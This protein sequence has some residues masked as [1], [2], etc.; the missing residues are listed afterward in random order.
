MKLMTIMST[1]LYAWTHSSTWQCW[2]S[3]WWQ[4]WATSCLSHYIARRRSNLLWKE[5]LIGYGYQQY[6]VANSSIG[7][8]FCKNP[9]KI[10][11]DFNKKSGQYPS[12]SPG[13]TKNLWFCCL[14][15]INGTFRAWFCRLANS[16]ITL[17]MC[18]KSQKAWQNYKNP[19][20]I[21]AIF[22][23]CQDIRAS[24]CTSIR[25]YDGDFTWQHS[26]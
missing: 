25:Q 7:L 23:K 11:A 3:S 21:Q 5:T 22:S 19:D 1:L 2:S 10:Q 6:S 15:V 9:G 16:S 17:W 24:H 26:Q 18:T 4:S 12:I 14:F 20:V 8:I 13:K